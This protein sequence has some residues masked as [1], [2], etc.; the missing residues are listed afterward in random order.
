MKNVISIIK[1][2][3]LSITV[4][5]LLLGMIAVIPASAA[6]K[7]VYSFINDFPK[8][9]GE[10]GW[11]MYCG[12]S[13]SFYDKDKESWTN[14]DT[15]QIPSSFKQN[16]ITT[17]NNGGVSYID[18]IAPK[19]GS[20]SIIF[21]AKVTAPAND[22]GDGTY[23]GGLFGIHLSDPKRSNPKEADKQ[24]A[25]PIFPAGLEAWFVSGRYELQD[26]ETLEIE[27]FIDIDKGQLVQ[28]CFCSKGDPWKFDLQAFEIRY[29]EEDEVSTP[30]NNGAST[31]SD[32]QSTTNSSVVQNSSKPTNSSTNTSS[33]NQST[34]TNSS[35][36]QN[37]SKPA[38]SSSNTASDNKSSSNSSGAQPPSKP[39]S[40]TANTS[41]DNQST[42]TTN[43]EALENSSTTNVSSETNNGNGESASTDSGTIDN[44]SEQIGSDATADGND[45][46]VGENSENDDSQDASTQQVKKSYTGLIVGIS[47]GFIVLIGAIV[48]V[49]VICHKKGII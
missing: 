23:G 36:V 17:C 27:E 47:I 11:R 24:S 13:S 44:S 5:A 37:S 48:A 43:S 40:S 29:D 26:G 49:F 16:V 9:Q 21:T 46:T 33:D 10:N 28:F 8:K 4:F 41:S 20:I 45:T 2:L 19:S 35:V 3:V 42:D 38:N 32:N 31:S 12:A 7:N 39:T 6:E 1:K 30:T 14:K 34:T 15:H 18:F 25:E 22:G